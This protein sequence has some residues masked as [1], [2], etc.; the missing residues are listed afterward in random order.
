MYVHCTYYIHLHVYL[1][2]LFNDFPITCPAHPMCT[3]ACAWLEM[4]AKAEQISPPGGPAM[5]RIPVGPV[6]TV[7]VGSAA[8]CIRI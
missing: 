8:Y 7:P 2:M 6:V 5:S 4:A 3:S 1:Y